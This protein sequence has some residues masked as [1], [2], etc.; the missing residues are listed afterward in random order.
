MLPD[1]ALGTTQGGTADTPLK[2][3]TETSVDPKSG[4]GT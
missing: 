4:S 2:P 1:G 3:T